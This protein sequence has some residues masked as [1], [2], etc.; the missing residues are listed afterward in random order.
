MASRK[1]I[2]TDA[3]RCAIGHAAGGG[4]GILR[5]KVT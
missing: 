2:F 4:S 3:R 1:T 5:R